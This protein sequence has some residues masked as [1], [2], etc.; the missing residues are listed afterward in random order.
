M[1]LQNI[2][3]PVDFPVNIRIARIKNIP[4]H[5]HSDIE[6]IFVLSGKINLTNSYGKFI[7]SE[8]D[9]FTNN[10]NEIHSLSETESEN[11]VAVIQ[12]SNE[13]FEK[14]FPDLRKSAYRTNALRAT[15]SKQ[16]DLRK[17]VLKILLQYM[18][19]GPNYKSECISG[20]VDLIKYLN[21]NFNV[22][23]IENQIPVSVR[24]E[25]PLTIERLS[26]II[27]YIYENYP[28]KIS[29]ENIA[30]ME[31]LSTFHLSHLI[32]K[33]TGMSF[34]DFLCFARVE[35][36]EI[37]LLDTNKKISRIAKDVGFSTTAYYE[38]YFKKWYGLSPED[39]RE[40]Y[41]PL[42]M[43]IVNPEQIDDCPISHAIKSIRGM[44]YGLSSDAENELTSK[45]KGIVFLDFSE[46]NHSEMP[47]Q[48][49]IK[50]T[51]ENGNP[52]GDTSVE[53]TM[54]GAEI[55]VVVRLESSYASGL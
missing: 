15:D 45:E 53:F 3:Y 1:L 28:N 46:E 17:L 2:N 7:L 47:K 23:V 36:S 29:L 33:Y 27:S 35:R 19:K 11:I 50:V 41:Q 25:N 18:R 44:L 22:F 37:P 5:Y 9:I 30:E 55:E 31:H 26:R 34:R 48:L 42:V 12:I 20:T 13:F 51:D 49:F 14:Y 40:N 54:E 8:G 6:F 43:S 16:D 24:E 10:G 21:Q 39:H 38:K 32:R 4:L 52:L